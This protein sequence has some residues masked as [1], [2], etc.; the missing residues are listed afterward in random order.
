MLPMLSSPRCQ[1]HQ[2]A[3]AWWDRL[4]PGGGCRLC[5]RY[6]GRHRSAMRIK[7]RLA[8]VTA[9]ALDSL[10]S[11]QSG[12]GL[13]EELS[14]A[15]ETRVKATRHASTHLPADSCSVTAT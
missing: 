6:G 3:Q 5:A 9:A 15:A 8:K 7:A 2:S 12:A 14:E 1:N 10:L 4:L 13:A 11:R